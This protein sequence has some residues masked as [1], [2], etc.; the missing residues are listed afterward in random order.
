MDRIPT[1]LSHEIFIKLARHLKD[2]TIKI[3]HVLH[4]DP[5]IL[6]KTMYNGKP[7][8]HSFWKFQSGRFDG[9]I[10]MHK[11]SIDLPDQEEHN[12][13]LTL[14]CASVRTFSYS[15]KEFDDYNR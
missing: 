4:K 3:E 9:K 6:L 13:I 15:L 10:H 5:G 2:A 7:I 12:F 11:E 8:S 14:N 1:E